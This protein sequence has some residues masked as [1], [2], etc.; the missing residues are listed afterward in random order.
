M[1]INQSTAESVTSY[2]EDS[3]RQYNPPPTVE[4]DQQNQQQNQ[5]SYK[6]DSPR[7]YNPPP[8]VY[9]DIAKTPYDCD[10]TDASQEHNK[11]VLFC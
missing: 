7:Q 10:E 4:S 1:T 6:E 9:K 11:L 5:T 8:T 2:K 3:P